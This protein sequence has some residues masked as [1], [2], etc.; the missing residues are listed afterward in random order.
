MTRSSKKQQEMVPPAL[1]RA[2]FSEQGIFV[3]L[4]VFNPLAA[5]AFLWAWLSRKCPGQA[6]PFSSPR[7]ELALCAMGEKQVEPER[8][9][10]WYQLQDSPLGLDLECCLWSGIWCLRSAEP[11]FPLSFSPCAFRVHRSHLFLRNQIFFFLIFLVRGRNVWG[12][13]MSS[14]CLSHFYHTQELPVVTSLGLCLHLFTALTP[15]EA[16][17]I[18]K[19]R[20]GGHLGVMASGR[21]FSPWYT[22][23]GVGTTFVTMGMSFHFSMLVAGCP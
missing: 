4:P 19:E 21:T 8:S 1:F 23:V 6:G 18:C 2:C 11:F 20:R 10:G 7:W 14:S 13:Q 5:F 22:A 12:I 17:C 3:S 15:M 16:L 9:K